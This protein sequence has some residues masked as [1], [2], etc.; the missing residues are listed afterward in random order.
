MKPLVGPAVVAGELDEDTELD[1][2]R[3][4]KLV[5]CQNLASGLRGSVA[6]KSTKSSDLA[7]EPPAWTPTGLEQRTGS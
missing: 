1:A 3:I 2:G 7:H 5:E 6:A 4:L